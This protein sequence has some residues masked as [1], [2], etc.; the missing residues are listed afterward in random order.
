MIHSRPRSTL[1]VNGQCREPESLASELE[2]LRASCGGERRGLLDG[3]LGNGDNVRAVNEVLA[4]VS[5]DGQLG[6]GRLEARSH[7]LLLVDEALPEASS[8]IVA[9][10]SKVG[11]QTELAGVGA[12][13]Q[14][15]WGQDLTEV[16][17]SS[18]DTYTLEQHFKEHLSVEDERSLQ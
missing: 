11:L 4:L 15:E 18:G 10:Q 16:A 5:E 9:G 7:E 14:R 3:G 13:G 2:V 12:L 17:L 8:A 6:H 1:T